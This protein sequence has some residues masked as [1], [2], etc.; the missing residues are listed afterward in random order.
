MATPAT[1]LYG[2]K[3]Q[4]VL[5]CDDERH[6]ARLLQVNL[7]RQGHTVACAFDGDEAI[8][9][10]ESAESFDLPAF[11]KVV[12][13][14]MMPQRDGYEVLTWIRTRERTRDAWVAMMIPRAQDRELWERQP[15]RA[16]LYVTK[17][18]SPADLFR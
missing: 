6:V 7:E 8:R 2:V 3:P 14:A 10:I 18:F 11:D 15:Y 13:D 17:P 9:L 16:D 5:V 12:L 1:A 4:R